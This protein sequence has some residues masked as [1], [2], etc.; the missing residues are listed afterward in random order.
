MCILWLCEYFS[1][2][3]KESITPLCLTSV[4]R[5]VDVWLVFPN[6][7]LM[8]YTCSYTLVVL[9]VRGHEEVAMYHCLVG[10][11]GK[12]KG[13][14]WFCVPGVTCTSRRVWAEYYV[15][16][17]IG[18]TSY[19]TTCSSRIHKHTVSLQFKDIFKDLRLRIK[20]LNRATSD[21]CLS[22]I[23]C[24]TPCDDRDLHPYT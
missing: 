2:P 15:H 18:L 12:F 13:N 21:Y 7:L 17:V 16:T 24:E 5:Q 4:L 20:D 14:V 10:K 11:K 19:V 3:L 6:V 8:T 22:S 1:D 9:R 23:R